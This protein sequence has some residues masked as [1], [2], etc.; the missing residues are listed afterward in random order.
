[1]AKKITYRI[2]IP[3]LAAKQRVILAP[4]RKVNSV[5]KLIWKTGMAQDIRKKLLSAVGNA[6]TNCRPHRNGLTLKESYV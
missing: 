5:A 2:D 4:P 3:G 1:L 6:E